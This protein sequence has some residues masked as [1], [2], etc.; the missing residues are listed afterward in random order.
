LAGE[1]VLSGSTG[2]AGA[3]R[4]T[5]VQA[6]SEL[7]R[8][9]MAE[10]GLA[11][12]SSLGREAVAARIAQK[13]L[14]Q[15]E[16]SYFHP[17]AALPGFARALAR[18]LLELR[19]AGI[20]A[21]ELASAGPP[22][23]DL[24]RLLE[25][26]E[27]ELAEQSLVDLPGLLA[28]ATEAAAE[29]GHP[30][31]GL[32]L[33]R[34]HV[35]LESRAHQEFFK[36]L[37]A[38][39]PEVLEAELG[40]GLPGDPADTLEHLRR[41]LFSPEPVPFAGNDG[42]FEFFS[43]PGEGLE[44]VEIARRILR[45][46]RE[47]T[48]F[49][50]VAILLRNADRYQPMIED[51]LRRAG[52][53]AWFSQG[54]ARP[55]PSGRAFLA[56]LGCASERLSASRFAEYLSLGQF[57]EIPGGPEWVAPEDEVMGSHGNEVSEP[58]AEANRPT[59]WRW[60]RLLVDA[61]VIGG[62]DRWERRLN[63]LEAEFALQEK[64]L[65]QIRNLKQFA[66]PLIGVLDELPSEATWSVWLSHLTELAGLSLREPEP[67]LAVLAE[68][69]PMGDVGLVTLEE[70][71]GVLSE[72]LRFLRRDPPAQRWGR[73]FV[74]SI[75]EARGREFGV[76]FLPGLAE[77]LFPQRM[78]EDPLLLDDFREAVSAYLPLREQRV[79]EERMRLHLAVAAARDRLIVSYPR[80]EVAE[81]RPRVPSFYAL[82]L[83]RAVEGSLPELKAFEDRAREAAPARLNWPAPK[84]ALD[85]I[86]NAEYDLVAI[87]GARNSP[88]GARYLVE[89]NPHVARSMRARWARWNRSWRPADGLVTADTAALEALGGQ[90][91]TARTWSPS[92]LEQFALCPYKFALHGIYKLRPREEGAP[93]EQMDPL[94]RGA[95]FHEI[96]FEL[97]Q[98]LERMELLPVN[99]ERLREALPLADAVL[100]RV[101]AKYEEDLAPA[102]PRVWRSEIEDLRTDLRG[103]L[104]HAARNDND[105]R[106]VEFE[107]A[108]GNDQPA[109]LA[110]GVNLRGRID[111]VEKHESRDVFRVTDHKTGKR[112]ETIP[113][114]V[115]GGRSLQPLLY[116]LVAEKLLGSRVEAGRL[117]YATQRG[118]YTPVEIKIDDRARQFLQKL[119]SDIDASIAGGFLPPAPAKDACVFCDYRIVCGPYEERRS[120]KKDRRDERLELLTEIRGM[121]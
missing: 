46:A 100:N 89:A 111:L 31:V 59:P 114:W 82:E 74:G 41:Y 23:A 108:F 15:A 61:A 50:Q 36:S 4:M 121:A 91:L 16:L 69:A 70:V 92:S 14:Q 7:A 73:V 107:L 58:A 67:V 22:A 37:A 98:E 57:P 112:P 76:V 87:A 117:L 45:L 83:P 54:T 66:L 78:L 11:P 109:T 84:D 104:Q 48:A 21:G 17:V 27:A 40:E 105:W 34:L 51:A 20:A 63:G 62:R 56:L 42:Q 106:P 6:A 116:G 95:L 96:Q 43:A 71:A 18:T 80:M 35:D 39:A 65:D 113:R 9:A 10:R 118:G 1:G 49:D 47:G 119:L 93:L 60:E 79:K 81:A 115:G 86:D 101:A 28:L 77:G 33:A 85:A 110:E 53:S 103:W 2:S 32:P 12:L 5:L 29:G 75:D 38:K 102:I 30:W 99:E 55:H 94:T 68:L 13:A 26:Y 97:F 44:A 64:P 90:R 3:H 19:L 52:I 88:G 72:R 24:G 120:G 8:P 25:S